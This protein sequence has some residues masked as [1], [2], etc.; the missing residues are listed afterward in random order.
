[1]G[2]RELVI[3]TDYPW[4]G[5]STI[6]SE[7]D[8]MLVGEDY[9]HYLA[10]GVSALQNINAAVKAAGIERI[11]TILDLPCGHGRVTRALRA[12]FP[13]AEISVSDLDT[14]GLEF[15]SS[16]FD[17]QPLT[18]SSNFR[19]LN[20]GKIFDLIWV[21]SLI[22][23]L[24][25]EMTLDFIFFILRHLSPKGVAVISSHGSFIAGRIQ[26]AVLQGGEGYGTENGMAR[27]ML[28]RYFSYG[29]GYADYP[30]TDTSIQS[31]GVSLIS[32]EWMVSSISLATGRLVFYKDHA[33]DRHH[34][35]VA[36]VRK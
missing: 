27:L 32:R 36:F 23:H 26:V 29:F 34:D 31:Y 12:V 13:S 16:Q 4:K 6:V 28:D 5:V 22:T 9:A 11:S 21:G 1:M 2:K 30:D 10:V 24:P 3:P 35:M 25:E 7:R 33:W 17:A 19:T 14:D 15:C 8:E 20:F 18:S